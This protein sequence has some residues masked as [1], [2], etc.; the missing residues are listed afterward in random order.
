M[1]SGLSVGAAAI[2]V[3]ALSSFLYAMLFQDACS[4][5]VAVLERFQFA[6]WLVCQ[7]VGMVFDMSL[8]PLQV[9]RDVE[10][11]RVAYG[12]QTGRG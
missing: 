6:V 2:Y 8:R 5:P 12:H 7:V 9:K 10:A 3:L 4:E 11:L 1:P